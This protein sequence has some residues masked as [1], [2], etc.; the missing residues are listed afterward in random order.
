METDGN[1]WTTMREHCQISNKDECWLTFADQAIAM[2]DCEHIWLRILE[3][4]SFSVVQDVFWNRK[5]T[6]YQ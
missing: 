2:I 3:A 4:C 6:E 5:D 1:L